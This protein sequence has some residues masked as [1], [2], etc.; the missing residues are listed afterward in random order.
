MLAHRIGIQPGKQ[1]YGIAL[2]NDEKHRPLVAMRVEPGKLG[3]VARRA[4]HDEIGAGLAH[5]CAQGVEP[6]GVGAGHALCLCISISATHAGTSSVA[7]PRR[8]SSKYALVSERS[9]LSSSVAAPW[10]AASATKP[11]AG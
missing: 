6:C 11:A 5:L 2:R 1:Y 9:R 8:R 7:G 10:A 4:E 3:H